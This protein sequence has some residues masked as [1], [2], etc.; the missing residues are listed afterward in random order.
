MWVLKKSECLLEFTVGCVSFSKSYVRCSMFSNEYGSV[1][2]IKRWQKHSKS[3]WV[4]THVNFPFPHFVLFP[5]IIS[6]KHFDFQMNP[7]VYMDRKEKKGRYS[8]SKK[9]RSFRNVHWPREKKSKDCDRHDKI[10]MICTIHIYI[11]LK[12]KIIRICVYAFDE[13]TRWEW[14]GT[15]R[16]QAQPSEWN[17]NWMFCAH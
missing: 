6:I 4:S 15:W 9:A 13:K 14:N 1:A 5:Y 10:K 7:N 16:S 11:K 17:C 2:Y 3:N 8:H 12:V